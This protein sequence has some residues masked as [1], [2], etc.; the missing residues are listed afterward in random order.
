MA[1]LDGSKVNIQQMFVRI[2]IRKTR[3]TDDYLGSGRK[4]F[5]PSWLWVFQ[6]EERERERG[7]IFTMLTLPSDLQRATLPVAQKL[8]WPHQGPKIN[9]PRLSSNLFFFKIL[10]NPSASLPGMTSFTSSILFPIRGFYYDICD[11]NIFN[12]RAWTTA[13]SVCT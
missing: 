2:G 11:C 12:A 6:H 7:A 13:L 9:S 3:N 8:V 1:C 4:L 10:K 5:L